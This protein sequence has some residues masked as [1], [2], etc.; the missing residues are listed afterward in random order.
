M[1]REA[2]ASNKRIA[3]ARQALKELAAKQAGK[4]P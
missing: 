1:K 4:A 3:T 2:D